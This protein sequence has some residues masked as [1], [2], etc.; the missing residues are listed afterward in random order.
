VSK[1]YRLEW[2]SEFQSLEDKVNKAVGEGY[3]I[4]GSAQVAISHDAII[5]VQ[6]LV[7]LHRHYVT[8]PNKLLS[9][10]NIKRG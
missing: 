1:E 3:A 2:S 7:K 4:V 8:D 5:V 6:T 9:P 10:G